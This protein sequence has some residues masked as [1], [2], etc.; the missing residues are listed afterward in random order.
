MSIAETEP[1]TTRPAWLA[2]DKLGV[3]IALVAVGGAVLPFALFRANRIVPGEPRAL[4]DALPGFS[5]GLLVGLLLA[6]TI[7]ALL[8]LPA[9]A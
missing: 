9:L 6:G 8:K 5:S 4:L 1:S 3:L 7:V 2:L